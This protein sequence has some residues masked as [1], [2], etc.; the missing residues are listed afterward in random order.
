MVKEGNSKKGSFDQ[1]SVECEGTNH[2]VVWRKSVVGRGTH[3]EMGVGVACL[4][5]TE[6]SCLEE[7]HYQGRSTSSR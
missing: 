5:I 3:H 2:V 6:E 4:R 1:R 7:E